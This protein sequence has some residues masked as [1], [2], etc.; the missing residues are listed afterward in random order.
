MN[1]IVELADAYAA[2]SACDGVVNEARAA[3]ATEVQAHIDYTAAVIAERDALKAEL[4]RKTQ[5]GKEWM[6]KYLD[7]RKAA[8]TLFEFLYRGC[9]WEEGK[10]DLHDVK[11]AL[12]KELT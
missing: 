11:E 7:L 12:R 4:E 2:H 8:Q 10:P 5:Y 1:R 3:L 9:R 6:D